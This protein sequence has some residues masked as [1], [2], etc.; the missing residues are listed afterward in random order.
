MAE[1]GIDEEGQE[2]RVGP[3]GCTDLS[4]PSVVYAAAEQTADFGAPQA[5]IHLR[6]FQ[7]SATIGRGFPAF[8]SL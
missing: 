1:A 5:T 3:M 2:P 7:L 6:L 4:S 8:A